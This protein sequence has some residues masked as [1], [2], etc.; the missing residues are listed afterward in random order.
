[1]KKIITFII[2]VYRNEL[3]LAILHNKIELIFSNTLIDYNYQFVFVD[4]G[5]DDKSLNELLKLKSEFGKIKIISF[6]RNFG[7][8]AAIIAGYKEAEGDVFINLSADLQEPIE[9]IPQMIKE[10][11]NGSEIVICYKVKRNDKF[12]VNL[13]SKIFYKL[14]RVSLPQMPD[15]GFDFILL[16]KKAVNEFNKLK[17]NNRYYQG[18]ILRLGFNVKF[19]PS[20]RLERKHGKSQWSFSKRFSYF[21]DAILNTAYWPIRLMS[22][23]G[24]LFAFLGFIYAI[25]VVY[26][27]IVNETPFKGYAPIVILLLIIGGLIMLMLGVIGEYVWRIFDET[28]QRPEYIIKEKYE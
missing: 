17:Q 9:L 3:S 7:Q 5:S 26:A 20:E 21:I 13:T 19:I 12:I 8:R 28:K 11:E 10:W 2:P 18:E 22:F 24:F 23:L 25:V 6:S 27:R 16:D 14:I 1:M 15:G 4:D